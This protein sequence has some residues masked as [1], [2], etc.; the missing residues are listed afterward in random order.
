MPTRV[1]LVTATQLPRADGDLPILVSS[2]ARRGI[3]AQVVPWECTKTNWS[4]FDAAI[5]RSTWNYVE[6]FPAFCAWLEATA[7]VTQLVNPLPLLR[8]NLHKGYLVELA[9]AGIPVVPTHVLRAGDDPDWPALFEHFGDLVVKP[10]VSAGSFATIRVMR[11]DIATV[12]AHHLE[13]VTR[14]FLVQPLLHSVSTHGERNM[15]HLGGVFSHA[16]YKGP[17]WSGDHEQ[18]RGV[19]TAQADELHLAARV[20]EFVASKGLGNAAY[21]RVDVAR[22]ANVHAVLMELEIVEPSLYLECAPE[23]A[24]WL[25]DAVCADLPSASA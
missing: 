16:I 1:A 6:H 7:R 12:T 14:D 10:A 23:H 11:G 18:S 5:I 8:W 9:D 21:A 4:E 22:D 3:D 17:R 15:V 20:L 24:R 19:V 25:V 2:F 13:H